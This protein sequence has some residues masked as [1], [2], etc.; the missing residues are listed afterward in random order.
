MS[1]RWTDELNDYGGLTEY[2]GE[3]TPSAHSRSLFGDYPIHIAAVRGSIEDL[4]VLL[5]A[6][7]NINQQGETGF[8]PLH[9]AALHG[10]LDTVLH[11]LKAG[12]ARDLRNGD[13]DTAYDVAKTLGE[14]SI[15]AAL[16]AE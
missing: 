8:T 6:G 16:R 5:H 11:L 4:Q 2:L 13:D 14:K 7:A 3:P 1:R 9:Y 15:I 10:H 12:A